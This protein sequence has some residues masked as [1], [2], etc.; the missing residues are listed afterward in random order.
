VPRHEIA[1]K[2]NHTE[3]QDK[4]AGLREPSGAKQPDCKEG[5]GVHQQERGG[6][7]NSAATGMSGH[8]RQGDAD[9]AAKATG[10]D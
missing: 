2:R 8:S 1:G 10:D 5:R 6:R 4:T 9:S 7:G 3:K